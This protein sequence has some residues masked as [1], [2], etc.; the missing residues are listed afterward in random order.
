MRY[1]VRD[2]WIGA[3]INRFSHAMD[4]DRGI[5]TFLSFLFSDTHKVFGIYALVRKMAILKQN[6]TDLP[7]LQKQLKIALEKD[8][9]L[10]GSDENFATLLAKELIKVAN[11]ATSLNQ[12]I[13]FQYFWEKYQG[14]IAGNKVILTLAYLLDGMYLNH[15]GIKLTWDRRK[16]LGNRK[17]GFLDLLKDY[18]HFSTF[19]KPADIQEIKNEVD[20]DEVTYAIT[21]Q[22]LIPNGFKIISIS[23]PGS[24]GGGAVLPEPEKGKE[25]PREY[26]DIIAVSPKSNQDVILNESKGMF[27]QGEI[28]KDTAKILRYK[29]E[30]NYQ[31]ALKETLVVAKV[32]DENDN[33]RNIIIGVAFGIK[34]NTTTTWKPDVVDFIFRVVDREKWAI[35]I[36]NQTLRDLIPII[37]GK[38]N[39]PKVYK[40]G[41]NP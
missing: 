13:D 8:E 9:W 34:S 2:T 24:Q 12:E 14:K 15:N 40:I 23:Y 29:T 19:T 20:E 18:F 39:F 17:G 21:H 30:A 36:F 38:T 4:P 31:K 35:G 6:I 1:F 33:I 25:Q 27:K 41:R 5:L 11:S 26:P 10:K 28:E 37:E 3:K 16:L 32:I 7:T 22:V